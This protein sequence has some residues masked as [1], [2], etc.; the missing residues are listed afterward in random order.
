M[1]IFIKLADQQFNESV[2]I[3]PLIFPHMKS[4]LLFSPVCSGKKK[5]VIF[6]SPNK[7]LLKI[8]LYSGEFKIH[9]RRPRSTTEIDWASLSKA[10]ENSCDW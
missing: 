7:T 9:Y 2:F 8:S 4:V 10:V 1:T 3:S 5:F 6:T